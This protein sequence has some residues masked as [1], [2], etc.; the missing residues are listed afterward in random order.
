MSIASHRLRGYQ[1]DFEDVKSIRFWLQNNFCANHLVF[2]V[3]FSYFLLLSV[4]FR[5]DSAKNSNLTCFIV[6]SMLQ[7]VR[8]ST[9]CGQV[10]FCKLYFMGN[11][12]MAI[13]LF[14]KGGRF[15]IYI[16]LDRKLHYQFLDFSEFC[17]GKECGDLSRLRFVPR[18]DIF[19]LTM[20]PGLSLQSFL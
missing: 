1:R 4:L 13:S 11:K 9:I 3:S 7:K 17:R 6:M 10:I 15:C 20:R 16:Y 19:C 14:S 2:W 12:F 5:I 8:N 18:Y